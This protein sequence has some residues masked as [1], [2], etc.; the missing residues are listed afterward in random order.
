MDIRNNILILTL[1]Y[2][3]NYGTAL[4]AYALQKAFE[5]LCLRA[6]HIVCVSFLKGD[7]T[8]PYKVI[9]QIC[10][11]DSFENKIL[12]FYDNDII[13]VEEIFTKESL[14]RLS[15]IS[16]NLVLG[17]DQVWNPTIL[18]EN[19]IYTTIHFPKSFKKYIYGAGVGVKD[20][21]SEF[22][23]LLRNNLQNFILCSCR[24]SWLPASLEIDNADK[25]SVVADPVLLF[26][27]SFWLKESRP[28]FSIKNHYVLLYRLGNRP[29]IES[30]A[31]EIAN[32][33]RLQL[34]DLSN[35]GM[36]TVGPREFLWLISNA[37]YVVTD[38]YHGLLFSYV[39][40]KTVKTFFKFDGGPLIQDN[41]RLQDASESLKDKDNFR[42]LVDN[43][44]MYLKRIVEH[45][46]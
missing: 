17:S 34:L 30:Y 32:Q 10:H 14:Y 45:V 12:D 43:S 16:S 21:T 25:L 39:F 3:A 41:F 22:K 2:N 38:S 27:A 24:D 11:A 19:S 4:Q 7:N 46:R 40:N 9:R 36:S 13:H 44:W 26:D 29:E 1:W 20:I 15:S 33:Q 35:I 42:K 5:C 31:K 8:F 18:N 37:D 23:K 6:L 28:V